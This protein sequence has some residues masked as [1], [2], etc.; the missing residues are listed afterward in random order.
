MRAV[1]LGPL[2]HHRDFEARRLAELKADRIVSVCLPAR[3]EEAT[4]G[5]VVERI[6][7]ELM[8][9]VPLVDEVIVVDDHSTDGTAEVAVA[10]GA[11]VVAAGSVLP[12]FGLLGGKGQALWKSVFVAEGDL[13]VWCDSDVEGFDSRFVRGLLGPL[14][15]DDEVMFVKGFYDRPQFGVEGGGRVTELVARP[16]LSLFFPELTDVRQPLS[17]EFAARRE[18][19]EALPFAGG[20]GVD[21]G[22]LVDVSRLCGPGAVAQVDMDERID[23]NRSLTELGAQAREVLEA[24]LRR[25][26]VRAGGGQ[27]EELPP[28]TQLAEYREKHFRSAGRAPTEH[29]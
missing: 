28:L 3:D 14:L 29:T 5:A 23:R 26:G 7:G 13:L 6:R 24:G 12:D 19:V 2:H 25:A 11:K 1:P 9:S 4:V 20:Y 27:L 8:E 22:L 18:V 21:L 15:G 17:G 16:L 10:A